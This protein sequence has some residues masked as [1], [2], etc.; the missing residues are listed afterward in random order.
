MP[1]R[2]PKDGTDDP[3]VIRRAALHHGHGRLPVVTL[4]DQA[5]GE[6]RVFGNSHVKGQSL[7]GCKLRYL[8]ES[9]FR[10]AGSED[11]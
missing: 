10:V 9:P 3:L 6:S 1:P 11:H 7:T 4:L 8:G 2:V 5:L